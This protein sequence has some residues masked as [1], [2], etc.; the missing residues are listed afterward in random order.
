[1]DAARLPHGSAAECRNPLL[2][3]DSLREGSLRVR[4][5]LRECRL[6]PRTCG[7]DRTARAIGF[8]GAGA[9]AK[10]DAVSLHFG[11]EPPISGTRGSGTVF[12]SHRNMTCLFC[13][14]YPISQRGNGKELTVGKLAGESL[15]LQERGAHSVNF[16]TPTP[17]LPHIIGAV[18]A[19]REKG[20][21]I[22]AAYNTNGYDSLEAMALPDGVVDI[23]LPDMKCRSDDLPTLAEEAPD[24]PVHNARAL[25]E[26]LR[27]TGPLAVEEGGIATRGV[28]IRHLVLPG[29]VDET[30][31]VLT[32]I[33][34]TNGPDM[35]LS[36]MGQY[37]QAYKAS[38]R[39]ND[40]KIREGAGGVPTPRFDRKLTA[41]EYDRA[42]GFIVRL[43][44][45]NVFIQGDPE[46]IFKVG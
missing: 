11:E 22:P 28:L 10:V 25:A 33:R 13:Q 31:A 32:F 44:F 21:T 16:V 45:E 2:E 27:Q 14:N 18:A 41:A 23:H 12:F 35:P 19:A 6:C 37:I 34:E 36:L 30:E 26:T 3:A 24:Y 1:V 39:N 38:D 40:M 42:V 29:R 15:R 17:N 7:A 20:F 9:E 5:A 43:E 46:N 8:C 4:N